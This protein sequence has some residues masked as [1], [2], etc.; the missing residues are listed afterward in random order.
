MIGVD[1]AQEAILSLVSPLP[2]VTRPLTDAIGHWLAEPLLARRTQPWRDISAMDGYAVSHGDGPWRVVDDIPAE[3][4]SP[5]GLEPGT[6]ARIFTGAP[7]PAGT[8]AIL[9]QENAIRA[10]LSVS[11]TTVPAAGQFIRRAGSDFQTGAQLMEPG[12]GITPALVALAAMAGH[13][14]LHVHCRPTVSVIAT[15]SELVAAG[16]A[17]PGLPSSNS[18]M[19]TGM[20]SAIGT[21]T[22]HGIVAD[23]LSAIRAAIARCRDDA[24]ILTGGASVGD[25]DLVR[26]AL[27]A[28]GWTIALHRVSMKPGK[29]VMVATKHG[30]IAFGLPG[31]PVSAFVTAILFALPAL[32]R[33]AGAADPL[34]MFRPAISGCA[35]PPGGNRTDFLRGMT[36]SDGRVVLAGSQDSATLSTLARADVLIR[37][38]IDAPPAAVGDP[39]WV[40]GIA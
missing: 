19:L 2:I 9:I 16:S 31:N 4:T 23:D 30:R 15:G 11:A 28:E 22:D 32:R 1:D 25:H 12:A 3:C 8:E 34:P 10:G 33:L 36:T 40:H 13:G 26:P 37:R 20:I 21:A 14:A 17:T 38:E 6:A 5:A 29:P 24:L 18:P 7:V 35:L 39:L 27:I